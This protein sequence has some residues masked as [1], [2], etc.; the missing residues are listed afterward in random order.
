MYNEHA[1]G[2][3]MYTFYLISSKQ[4]HVIVINIS[5]LVNQEFQVTFFKIYNQIMPLYNY[6]LIHNK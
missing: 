2:T 4:R 1:N 6:Y 3:C 5:M